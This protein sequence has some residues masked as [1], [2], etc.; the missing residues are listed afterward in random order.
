MYGVVEI[1]G[2][3]YKVQAGDLIDVEK[4]TKDAGSMIELDQVLF[5]GGEKPAI[6]APVVAGAKITAKVIM[7]DR[8]R[9]LIVFKRKPGGYKRRNGHRQHFTALLITEIN[10]GAGNVAKIDKASKNAEKYLK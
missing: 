2:H 1:A 9:K 4:L 6:G 7:H 5:I 10:D 3:Q 8:S